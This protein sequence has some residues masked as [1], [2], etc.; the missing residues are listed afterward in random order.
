M[1][2]SKTQVTIL[3]DRVYGLEKDNNILRTDLSQTQ[4]KLYQLEPLC[5]SLQE[6]KVKWMNISGEVEKMR[7]IFEAVKDLNRELKSSEEEKSSP[8]SSLTQQHARW[9]SLPSLRQ[10]SSSLYDRIVR[11]FQD[12]HGKELE[13]SESKSIIE[14]LQQEIQAM[15]RDRNSAHARDSERS[16]GLELETKDLREKLEI[17]ENQLASYRE[18][19]IILDQIHTVMKTAAATTLY[20]LNHAY[21]GDNSKGKNIRQTQNHVDR[22]FNRNR[23]DEN[24]DNSTELQPVELCL[25]DIIDGSSKW[26]EHEKVYQERGSHRNHQVQ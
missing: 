3:Q 5:K 15:E 24:V 23:L 7:S 6:E 9:C 17:T 20:S 1:E 25:E 11:L 21:M 19:K 10:I 18:V 13:A 26:D 12:M 8:S 16:Y 4:M 14:N 2:S 22:A